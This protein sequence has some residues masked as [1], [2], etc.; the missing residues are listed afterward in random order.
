[1]IKE[2]FGIPEE[3]FKRNKLTLLK[4]QADI[5]TV[6]L[7]HARQGGLNIVIGEPGTGKSILRNDL[8]AMAQTDKSLVLACIQR[9]MHTYTNI[10]FQLINAL[11]LTVEKGKSKQMEKSLIEEAHR[12]NSQGRKLITIIDEAHLLDLEVLR[13]LRLLFDEFPNNHNII[14]F[15]QTELLNRLSMR[16]YEDMKSRI[17]YSAKLYPLNQEQM[18]EY[19]FKEIQDA[20]LPANVFDENAIDLIIRSV[21]GNLR[22][23]RNLCYGSLVETV[24]AKQ[25]IVTNQMVNR[26]LIQPHWRSHEELIT[27]GV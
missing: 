22:L 17:T 11:Q 20:E 10:L 3:P 16:V 4:Q 24:H 2:I 13:K 19:I 6:L 27:G 21:D 18:M 5:K 15:A 26:V 23:C 25:K 14:L 9:T 12:I 8:E 1:M 7:M